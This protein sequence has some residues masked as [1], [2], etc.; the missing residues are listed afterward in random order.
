MLLRFRLAE[1]IEF[2]HILIFDKLT[3]QECK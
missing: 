2:G 1:S 3:Q